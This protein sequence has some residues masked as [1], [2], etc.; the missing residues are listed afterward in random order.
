MLDQ[1]VWLGIGAC[2]GAEFMSHRPIF[3][4]IV[5]VL[6]FEGKKFVPMM[7]ARWRHLNDMCDSLKQSTI[8][9]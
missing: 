3:N 5:H 4:E 8:L 7:G 9:D 1:M 2:K 6:G